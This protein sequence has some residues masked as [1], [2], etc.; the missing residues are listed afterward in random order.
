MHNTLTKLKMTLFTRCPKTGRINGVDFKNSM[1]LFLFPVLGFAAELNRFSI[2]A[3]V[4][5]ANYADCRFRINFKTIF[6]CFSAV[7]SVF[8]GFLK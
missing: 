8:H 2:T 1:S 4:T 7:F 6:G 3:K 5:I